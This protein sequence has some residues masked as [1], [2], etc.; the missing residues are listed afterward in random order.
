MIYS[1][2]KIFIGP[3]VYYRLFRIKNRI[4]FA[5][6]EELKKAQRYF[7]KAI[8]WVYNLKTD[9]CRAAQIHTGKGW[10]LK[11]DIKDFYGSVPYRDIERFIRKVCEKIKNADTNYYLNLVTVDKKLPAGAPTSAHIANACFKK[12]ED[13]IRRIC[14]IYGVDFSRFMDDLTFSSN[15]KKLLQIVE[16]RVKSI[17]AYYGYRA[18]PKKTKYIS[19]NKQQKVLGLVVN[20]RAVCIINEEKRR[21]RAALHN[22]AVSR[23]YAA[24]K[25]IKHHLWNEKEV[26]KLA[27]KIAYI[28]HVDP[29]FY[30]KLKRYNAKLVYKYCVSFP[31][32]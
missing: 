11:I 22:Y 25:D 6:C 26:S 15:N 10:V 29:G 2:N 28:R 5:P 12:A 17:L 4:I 1:D 24:K 20:N 32:F 23:A 7:L 31:A 21:I 8:K 14:N 13:E 9:T 19:R 30:I 3:E 18:N 16:K 27:G